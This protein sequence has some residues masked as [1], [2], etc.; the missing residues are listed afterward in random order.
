MIAE[1][2]YGGRI[3]DDRDRRLIKVYAKEIFEDMLVALEK[4]RPIGTEEF[5]YV[6]PADEANTKHPDIASIFTP[7]Y[8]L[9]EIMKHFENRDQPIAFGQHTNA[10]ITSQIL[11]TNELL[12]SIITLMP[13]QATE[14]GDSPEKKTLAIIEPIKAGVPD[15]IDVIALK[16]KMARDDSP[17]TVVL[18]QEIQRYNILLAIMRST[19]EQLE[20]GI[21]GLV[22]ISPELEKMMTSLNQNLVP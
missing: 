7:D 1:C 5:N 11:D 18:I 4:W 21:M 6:Y 12:Y 8:F 16:Y 22:V 20:K 14:G 15:S 19:L 13:A 2:N 3:T 10:E 17:L 9:Q